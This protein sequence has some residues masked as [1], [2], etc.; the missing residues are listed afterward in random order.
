MDYEYHYHDLR[1]NSKETTSILKSI[2]W[3][4]DDLIKKKLDK[5]GCIAVSSENATTIH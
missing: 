5:A 1:I 2:N 3:T 4:K